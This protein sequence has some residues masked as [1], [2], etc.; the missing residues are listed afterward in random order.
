MRSKFAH[1]TWIFKA[2]TKKDISYF[3]LSAEKKVLEVL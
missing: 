2:A 3:M 1:T